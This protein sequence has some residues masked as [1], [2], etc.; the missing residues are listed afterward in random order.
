MKISYRI[1]LGF[2]VILAA[3]FYFLISWILNDVS[4]QPKKA[5]EEALV[6][7]SHILAS[8]LEQNIENHDGEIKISTQEM[9]RFM[10]KAWQR[11][12]FAR[13]YERQK[14]A[15]SIGVYVT[16]IRGVVVFDSMNHQWEG[17]DFSR[18]TDV[19]RTLRGKYGAR[20][21]RLVP[22][23]PTTS[24]AFVAAPIYYYGRI[25]GVCTVSKD[26]RSINSFIQTTRRTILIAAFSLFLGA[27]IISFYIARWITLPI[28]RLTQYADSIKD[29]KRCV[30]PSL[31]RGEIRQLGDSFTAMLDSLEGKKYIERYIQT[32]THQLKGPLSAIRGAAELLQEELPEQDR[33][34]FT[35]N[36]VNE[37]MRLQRIVERMLELASLE[38]QREL[39]NVESVDLV[40]LVNDIAEE[41]TIALK[42][43]ELVL[44]LPTQKKQVLK[45]ERFLLHQAIYNLLQNAVEF[46]HQGGTIT[47]EI[48]PDWN[49]LILIIKDDGAGIPDYALNKI[50]D[51]FY[52]LGRPDTGKKS[53]GLGLS[54]VKEVAELHNG[55]VKLKPNQPRGAMAILKLAIQPSQTQRPQKS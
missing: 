24:T 42:K 48:K 9:N 23:D 15:V 20:T 51:K 31:G 3:G 41:M 33:V 43:K 32:L 4:I 49:R 22:A 25:V 52:S 11:Q 19:Y 17:Q 7:M 16:D 39:R 27:L 37:S 6:D 12:V 45:G 55:E 54:L 26:W 8:Y 21:S 5:M 13:I 47:V 36:I 1:F 2:A 46:S 14:K 30:Y 38:Q 35:G 18:R 10:A 34:R 53:S 44:V 28:Q 50:F 29:G 40:R